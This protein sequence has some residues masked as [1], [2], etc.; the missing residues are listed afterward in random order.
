MATVVEFASPQ[1]ATR[2]PGDNSSL[3]KNLLKDRMLL[4]L[5]R[6]RACPCPCMG[7]PAAAATNGGHRESGHQLAARNIK[8]DLIKFDQNEST[9]ALPARECKLGLPQGRYPVF[10]AEHDAQ[11]ATVSKKSTVFFE[12]LNSDNHAAVHISDTDRECPFWLGSC[13][14]ERS[15]GTPENK[16]ETGV[17]AVG[18]GLEL[19]CLV[20]MGACACAPPGP[21]PGPCTMT[22]S[23]AARWTCLFLACSLVTK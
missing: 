3:Q 2:F 12:K 5:S 15:K 6:S 17:I 20:G 4:N 19:W 13:T 10:D 21:S 11:Q 7:C 22:S 14:S 8:Y 1:W 16:Q 23:T 18:T 9:F